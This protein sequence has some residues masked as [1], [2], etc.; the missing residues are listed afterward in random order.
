MKPKKIQ[1]KLK[2]TKI[3]VANLNQEAMGNAQAGAII[4]L[5][6]PGCIPTLNQCTQVREYCQTD[7]PTCPTC[8][9]TCG[10]YYCGPVEKTIEPVEI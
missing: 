3:T 1:N 10:H 5:S 8:Y 9:N 2:L 6:I 4:I 7:L